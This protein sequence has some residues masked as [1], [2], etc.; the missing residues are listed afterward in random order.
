M[1]KER[2]HQIEF[3][4]CKRKIYPDTLLGM[5]LEHAILWSGFGAF[6]AYF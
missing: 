3:A 1:R 5:K 2:K 4:R 6:L